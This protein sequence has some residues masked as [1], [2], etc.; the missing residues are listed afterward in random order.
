MAIV[1]PGTPAPSFS[2]A[3]YDGS[4]FTEQDLLGQRTVLVFYPFAFSEV[5]TDQLAIYDSVLDD[6]AEQGARL[7]AVSCDNIHAQ[8]AFRK[9]LGIRI[10]QLSDW[11]PK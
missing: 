11:E 2:L 3:R 10:E 4:T 9:E 7:Y 1:E 8:E 6:M 5:C